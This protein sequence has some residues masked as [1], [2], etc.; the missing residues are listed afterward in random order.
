MLK[1]SKEATPL[2]SAS[3][4]SGKLHL[5]F[6]FGPYEVDP[7]ARTLR[8]GGTP[9][10]L[11]EQPWQVL[12]ALLERPG[13]VVTREQLQERLWPGTFVDFE[14]GLNRAVNKLR[15]V[16]S[17]SAE[18]PRFVETVVGQGYRFIAPVE[19]VAALQA[20]ALAVDLRLRR[21]PGRYSH[22]GSMAVA[23]AQHARDSPDQRR[24]V[25][26]K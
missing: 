8:K 1:S 11:P 10:H 9:I 4:N 7:D 14:K 26:V 22:Y 19:Q 5:R 15:E 25:E 12:C 6:R 2:A 13:A 24:T 18:K 17:D 20:E 23:S 21:R 16:L 3:P